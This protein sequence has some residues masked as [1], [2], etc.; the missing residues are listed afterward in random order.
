[1]KI[2]VQFILKNYLICIYK[3]LIITLYFQ[4]KL[5]KRRKRRKIVIAIKSKIKEAATAA[6]AAV[7]NTKIKIKTV[8]QAATK[9]A[10]RKTF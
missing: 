9:M 10:N 7:H 6:V 5:T 3:I 8:N 4:I 1:M 2:S